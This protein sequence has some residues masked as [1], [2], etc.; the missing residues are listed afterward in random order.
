VFKSI[1]SDFLGRGA[2][3]EESPSRKV[4]APSTTPRAGGK[5]GNKADKTE[6]ERGIPARVRRRD[7]VAGKR[8]GREAKGD[9]GLEGKGSEGGESGEKIL[10]WGGGNEQKKNDD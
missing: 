4:Q 2:G 8:S 9:R 10:W 6:G 3:G 1:Y 7:P 5:R